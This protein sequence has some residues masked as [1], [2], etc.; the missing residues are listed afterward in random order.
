MKNLPNIAPTLVENF[1][2]SEQNNGSYTVN[3]TWLA[4]SPQSNKD[5]QRNQ[6]IRAHVKERKQPRRSA[7]SVLGKEKPGPV[8]S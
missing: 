4:F 1:D 8:K 7:S 3:C 2:L 5:T 6:E